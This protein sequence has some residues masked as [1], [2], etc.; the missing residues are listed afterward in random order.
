M[1]G[2]LGCGSG[3]G[4]QGTSRELGVKGHQGSWQGCRVCQGALEVA[5]V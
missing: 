4:A 1:S 5:R 3:V 2:A